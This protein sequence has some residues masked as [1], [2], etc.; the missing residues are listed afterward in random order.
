MQMGIRLLKNR[1]RLIHAI[2]GSLLIIS[3]SL[4]LFLIPPQ[5]L[6]SGSSIC[7]IKNVFGRECPGCGLTRAVS[8]VLHLRLKDAFAYNP[9]ILV[10]FPLLTLIILRYL[11]RNAKLIADALQS[12]RKRNQSP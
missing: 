11:I 4:L 1:K 10:V 9:R 12:S 7:L 6:D 2:V 5:S 8:S 3:L